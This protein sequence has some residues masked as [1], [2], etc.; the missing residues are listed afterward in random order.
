LPRIAQGAYAWLDQGAPETAA[1]ELIYRLITPR[2]VLAIAL[3]A[4]RRAHEF[5]ATV[6]ATAGDPALSALAQEMAAE[7]QEHIAMVERALERAPQEG[8]D[9]AAVFGD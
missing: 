8:V 9:W 4:E 6:Q 3:H 5:F 1:R 2:Q 7:E